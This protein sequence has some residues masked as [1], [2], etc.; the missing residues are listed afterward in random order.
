MAGV[1]RHGMIEKMGSMKD[2][3][4]LI[5]GLGAKLSGVDM[6]EKQL[7]RTRAIIQSMTPWE[8]AHP[9]EI[10]GRRRLRI[11]KGSGHEVPQVNQLLKQFEMMRGA[12]KKMSGLSDSGAKGQKAQADV[13]EKM[14]SGNKVGKTRATKKKF[15]FKK[16][17][18]H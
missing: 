18:K 2:L 1:M 12:M 3:L 7:G 10:A 6:D 16:R 14:M 8:R 17:R 15:V 4:G 5:P 9:E 13:M 11:A